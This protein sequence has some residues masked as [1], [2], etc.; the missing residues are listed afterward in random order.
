METATQILHRLNSYEPGREWDDVISD[1]R[2]VLDLKPDDFDRFPLFYKRYADDLPRFAL[3]RDLP[4]TEPPAVDVLAGTAQVAA[5]DLDLPH[6]ARLLH[7]SAGVVRTSRRSNG[8]THLF[9]AAGSAGGRFPLELYVLLPDG[10]DGLPAGVHWYDP[11][12]HALVR[13]A[14]APSGGDAALVVT[15]VPW[16][17]GWRYRERGF[18]HVYWDAG[19]M[20][21]QTLA[22]ARSAGIPARL[23]TTFPDR[24]VTEL[25]GADGVHEW[26]V[27][28]VGLGLR[29][30]ASTSSGPAATGDVDRDPVEF[31][32]VTAAQRAGDRTVLGEPWAD[33]DPVGVPETGAGPVEAVVLA[34]G[35]QRRMDPARTVPENVLTTGLR[36]AVRGI[37]LPQFVAVH[38]VDG[39]SPGVYRWPDLDTPIHAGNQRDE[40]YRVSLEQGLS[41]DAAFVV[42]TAA[43]VAS[44]DDREYRAAQ[45]A[46]GL[47]EGRLHLIAYAMGASAT[48]MT[49]LD[50]E[51]PALVGAP[52]DA[53]ILTCVGVPDYRATPGGSPGA[54]ADVRPMRHRS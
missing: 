41:R 19:T 25:V 49:F 47:V 45:L 48:G 44:L 26:P 51:I 13:V 28:V 1:P 2:L 40:L 42:I 31:P 23:Y 39:V 33:G 3:P 29:R 34:R 36:L 15:G 17:T 6:L 43:D 14:P 7:L 22:L 32:L 18:R 37:D 4:P 53:L 35:S 21:A 27:A 50:S 11:A 30:P 8:I 24:A 16:R 54:P 46:A 5:R 10:L 38:A 20:L 9:R 12:G 52:L